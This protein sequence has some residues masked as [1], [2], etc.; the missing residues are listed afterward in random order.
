[1]VFFFISLRKPCEQ[2]KENTRLI[3]SSKSKFF[4]IRHHYG[5][6]FST[7]VVMFLPT[8]EIQQKTGSR[9]KINSVTYCSGTKLQSDS[10]C[11][12]F[13][14]SHL[15]FEH[16]FRAKLMSV[17]TPLFTNLLTWLAWVIFASS[18][19][20]RTKTIRTINK[21]ISKQRTIPSDR[22]TIRL[23]CSELYVYDN[24]RVETRTSK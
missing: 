18:S 7:L 13:C 10:V 14:A 9:I 11:F 1:M 2:K 4:C 3:C 16:P 15:L 12:F 20:A 19:A 22:K 6:M 21:I 17:Q 24:E 8:S 5:N 23:T